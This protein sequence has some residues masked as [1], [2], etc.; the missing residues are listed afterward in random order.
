M[1][2]NPCRWC[3]ER[4]TRNAEASEEREAAS[5]E[6]EA[7]GEGHGQQQESG[8]EVKRSRCKFVLAA[9]AARNGSNIRN[10]KHRRAEAKRKA[11]GSR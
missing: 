10:G 2:D 4:R 9:T 1:I 6:R 3:T 5:H 7:S 8:R 11:K